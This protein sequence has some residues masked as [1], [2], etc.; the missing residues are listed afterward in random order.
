MTR[1]TLKPVRPRAL[2]L[3][4]LSVGLGAVLLWIAQRRPAFAAAG[5]LL[6]SISSPKRI[7]PS[8]HVRVTVTL[9]NRSDR[10]LRVLEP[11]MST[12]GIYG[13][14]VTPKGVESLPGPLDDFAAHPSPFVTLSPGSKL[15]RRLDLTGKVPRS[16]TPQGEPRFAV[17]R[18]TLTL[19][20]RS[21]P[22]P[23]HPAPTWTGEVGPVT[24]TLPLVNGGYAAEELRL[25]QSASEQLRS[26]MDPK[27]RTA[28]FPGRTQSLE[29]LLAAYP[30][31]ALLETAFQGWEQ[32]AW[33]LERESE[34]TRLSRRVLDGNYGPEVKQQATHA[35]FEAACRRRDWAAAQQWLNSMDAD[36]RPWY[37][38]RVKRR[39]NPDTGTLRED[40]ERRVQQQKAMARAEARGR[41]TSQIRARQEDRQR[42]L[43]SA[44]MLLP[45]A[46]GEV[47]SGAIHALPLSKLEQLM[48]VRNRWLDSH[49]K[50]EAAWR[51]KLE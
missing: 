30:Q 44:V 35:L 40:V 20:Y 1:H 5:P 36:T 2:I 11:M 15:T 34:I 37:E 13:K 9:E 21:Q 51:G 7:A 3:L 16:V 50:E 46:P 18:Y 33:Y 14:L 42:W 24:L 8:G 12:G 28:A 10:P 45:S 49:P 38:W 41:R 26:D 17:G 23:G 31:S 4:A 22:L 32:E 48:A 27:K 43:R 25:W 29:K 47:R 19:R 6:F 39:E